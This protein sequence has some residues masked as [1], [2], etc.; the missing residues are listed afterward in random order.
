MQCLIDCKYFL[1]GY[2]LRGKSC[3]YRHCYRAIKQGN[4]VCF[5]WPHTCRNINCHYLH[6]QTLSV[7]ESFKK[8]SQFHPIQPKKTPVS[9]FWDIEN[10]HVPRMQN[11]SY[12]VQRLRDRFVQ[13]N[14]SL[15]I[16]FT[17]YVCETSKIPRSMLVKLH[18]A[19]V[20]ITHVP[21]RK[22]GAVDR[23]ILLD[24]DR[25]ERA[26]KPPATI[27]LIS[28]DIDYA[29]KLTDLRHQAG[30][31]VILVHNK[32]V[33]EDLWISIN[34]HYSWNI[35][36]E[37]TPIQISA[38]PPPVLFQYQ[39][40]TCSNEFRTLEAMHQ[41]QDAKD[42]LFDCPIC[43]E[44][45]Y[46]T[47]DL[48]NHQKEEEHHEVE[49]SCQDC[50]R[51]FPTEDRLRQHHNDSHCQNNQ[52]R[53]LHVSSAFLVPCCPCCSTTFRT[54]ESLHQHQDAKGHVFDCPACD[55]SF[56]TFS[57]RDGHQE[58]EENSLYGCKGCDRTFLTE[59]ALQQ[60]RSTKNH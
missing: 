7:A 14:Q 23:Q 24:L 33:R 10:V 25:F 5:K 21:D 3:H 48:N 55:E 13:E 49:F 28:S 37:P 35:F 31:C 11:P 44:S 2:C 6:P 1:N 9:F 40:Q 22:P 15:E 34:A 47:D 19:N 27:V 45:F 43:D 57:E 60:H 32:P 54:L 58:D 53:E 50:D 56:Y 41:H 26:H 4:E 52:Q 36:T 29:G 12:I 8:L 18:N 42:H 51:S 46:T 20:R 59:G 16:G 38:P 17:C 39:C 30:F